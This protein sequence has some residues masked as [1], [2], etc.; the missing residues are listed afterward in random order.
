MSA[1]VLDEGAA[2]DL[3]LCVVDVERGASKLRK[4]GHEEEEQTERLNEG[5]A[6]LRLG[7]VVD[8][9]DDVEGLAQHRH[10]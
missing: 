4:S 10:A 1:A 5:V 9:L 3:G 2:D 7:L 8:D 6:D